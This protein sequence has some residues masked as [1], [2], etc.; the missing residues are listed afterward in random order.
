MDNLSSQIEGDLIA[1]L[2]DF[3]SLPE[4]FD[5]ALDSQI[6]AWY[7]NPP[8][9]WPQKPYFSPSS[10]GSCPRELYLKAK[11]AKRDAGR[12]PPHQARQA[13]MGTAAGDMIQRELLFIE[14]HYERL[15]GNAPRFRFLRDEQGR[16]RFEEFAKANVKVTHNGETFYL[17][18]APDG[19]MEYITDDGEAIRVG[20]E[21]KSKASTAAKTS[22]YSMREPDASHK[23]Q[24]TAYARMYGCDYYVVLYLNLAKKGWFMSDEDYAKTPDLRAFCLR[25]TDEDIAQILDKP[26]YVTRCVRENTPPPLDLDEWTFNNYKE[27]CA[28]DLSVAEFTELCEINHKAQHSSI[29]ASKKR[30]YAAAIEFITE[31]REAQKRKGTV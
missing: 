23:T 30:D 15:T 19:I 1:L 27:A 12:R 17:S 28:L 25:I 6:H 31:K 20:L 11:G 16:P 24:A 14:K 5:D 10:L 4:V 21:V 3:Q 9:V 7:V 22:L 13:K 18:G 8:K 2:D 26:A 29:N